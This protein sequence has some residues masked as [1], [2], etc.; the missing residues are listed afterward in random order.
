MKSD[1]FLYR[2]KKKPEGNT[3]YKKISPEDED[4][5]IESMKPEESLYQQKMGPDGKTYYKQIR[6]ESLTGESLKNDKLRGGAGELGFNYF[7]QKNKEYV[8]KWKEVLV[9]RQIFEMWH[10]LTPKEQK[11]WI[12]KATSFDKLFAMT[13]NLVS[14]KTQNFTDRSLMYKNIV[15]HKYPK[16]EIGN[17]GYNSAYEYFISILNNFDEFFQK[18]LMKEF[19]ISPDYLGK[20]QKNP[21]ADDGFFTIRRKEN[22]V[23]FKKIIEMW[24]EA[25]TNFPNKFTNFYTHQSYD[26]NTLWEQL[27]EQGRQEWNDS[28][29]ALE[30]A[31]DMF[32]K[33][34][35]ITNPQ[36]RVTNADVKDHLSR[37]WEAMDRE[38]QNTW[39]Y[40]AGDTI[41]IRHR[42]VRG[43]DGDFEEED[44]EE[45]NE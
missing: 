34:S 38:T 44:F 36:M 1:E 17:S 21:F 27:G 41:P 29:D 30:H 26:R 37:M 28:L 8:K 19:V 9:K 22:S 10:A 45:D 14:L 33:N 16:K 15:L 5:R 24:K 23:F 18:Q 2:K 13:N 7:Y 32:C 43:L 31:Y 20:P 3:Y 6:I 12:D 4:S 25:N 40:S 42:G 39:N 11:V 35:K